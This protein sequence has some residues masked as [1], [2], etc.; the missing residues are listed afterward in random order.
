MAK[1]HEIIFNTTLL[2]SVYLFFPKIDK[3]IKI[4]S[5]T[6]AEI[7]RYK[8]TLPLIFPSPIPTHPILNKK[9]QVVPIIPM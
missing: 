5:C 7:P 9:Q 3:I 6:T 8:S 1:S 2:L 4:K